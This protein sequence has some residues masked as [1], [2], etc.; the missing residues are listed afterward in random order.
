[1]IGSSLTKGATV[2]FAK[3]DENILRSTVWMEPDVC[4]VFITMLLVARPYE[5]TEPLEAWDLREIKMAGYQ[6][7]PGRY[8]MVEASAPG[9]AQ[10]AV[11]PLEKTLE[12][13]EKLS[14]EEGDPFSKSLVDGFNGRR[15]ARVDGGFLILNFEKYRN[16]RHSTERTRAHRARAAAGEGY[17][18][19]RDALTYLNKL[20]GKNFQPVPNTLEMF[21]ARINE[22]SL[23][24]VKGVILDRCNRWKNDEKMAEYLRPSTLLRASN[25]ANYFGEL[26]Q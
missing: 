3:I 1:M 12:C 9:I 8:G 7:P 2:S 23:K 10:T 24:E 15:I 13:L 25:F 14:S 5:V 16:K 20:T 4:R 19:A 6:I 21:Q 26:P 17:E 11:M 22:Y 18:E